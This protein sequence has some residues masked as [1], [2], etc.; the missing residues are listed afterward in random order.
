MKRLRNILCIAV[1]LLSSIFVFACNDNTP[2][3][4]VNVSFATLK[5]IVEKEDVATWQ[6][7]S[8]TTISA[9]RGNSTFKSNK[10]KDNNNAEK[11]DF[12]HD[13]GQDDKVYCD[14]GIRYHKEPNRNYI[15]ESDF[16]YKEYL[17]DEVLDG[18]LDTIDNFFEDNDNS[19]NILKS[20]KTETETNIIYTFELS[21]DKD[22]NKVLVATYTLD[23]EGNLIS[24][25]FSISINDQK[26]FEGEVTENDEIIVTPEWFKS[27]EYK[28][29][30]TLEEM[31]SIVFDSGLFDGWTS[32]YVKDEIMH[33]LGWEGEDYKYNEYY[34]SKENLTSGEQ[35]IIVCYNETDKCCIFDGVEYIYKNDTA[36][37]VI[38]HDSNYTFEEKLKSLF[39]S[40]FAFSFEDGETMERYYTHSKRYEKDRTIYAFRL[41]DDASTNPN[42]EIDEEAYGALYFDVNGNFYKAEYRMVAQITNYE[43]KT[44]VIEKKNTAV[45]IPEWFNASDFNN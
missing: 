26:D 38:N 40:F 45:E 14:D 3:S 17:D 41:F 22:N 19:N 33:P 20:D 31:Y 43:E 2:P 5:T 36:D 11:I 13:K 27:D 4:E 21:L 9:S 37:S 34:L 30:I 1:M 29:T 12:E 10:H 44:T 28:S 6:G 8:V 18:C 23:K 15:D 32:A 16:D 7:L 39:Y 35:N 42:I 24:V 25:K